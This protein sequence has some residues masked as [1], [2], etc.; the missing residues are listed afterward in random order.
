MRAFRNA[1]VLTCLMVGARAGAQRSAPTELTF[2]GA[3]GNYCIS[4][5]ADPELARQMVAGGTEL[6][7]A[8]TGKGLSVLLARTVR[9]EPR[10]AAWIPGELCIG[11]FAR[12]SSEGKTIAQAR[13]GGV[14]AVA[15]SALAA[16]SPHG[17]DGAGSYLISL[18]TDQRNLSSFAT[19]MGV[20]MDGVSA[21]SKQRGTDQDPDVTISAGGA[22]IH[23]SGH[24]VRDSSVGT[25]RTV[26]F[27]YAGARTVDWVVT[28]KVSP[29]T[30]KALVGSLSVTGNN[31]FAKALKT[32]PIRDI[33]SAEF[34]GTY[35][36]TLQR[37]TRR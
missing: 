33:S 16:K 15:T 24:P 21:V 28:I 32:S 18:M 14:I 27:G 22:D 10:F 25:T 36:I 17:V 37:A 8:G 3:S 6:T 35:T 11:F 30:S 9:D 29:A 26:S 19:D 12:V 34:G 4:Y 7:P 20:V 5:L 2:E 23:W 31:L 13:K 1:L